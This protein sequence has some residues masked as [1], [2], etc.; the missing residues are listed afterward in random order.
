M[1]SY[2]VWMLEVFLIFHKV[3][4]LTAISLP[5]EKCGLGMRL[6]WLG[7]EASVAWVRG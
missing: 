6:V 3:N 2:F 7:Y 4:E 5:Y 1:S